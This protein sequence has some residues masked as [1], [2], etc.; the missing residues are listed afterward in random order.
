MTTETLE[1][2]NGPELVELRN[3][4]IERLAW[5]EN[6]PVASKAGPVKR[7]VSHPARRLDGPTVLHNPSNWEQTWDGFGEAPAWAEKLI[8]R[9]GSYERA[10]GYI[11]ALSVM[12]PKTN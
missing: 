12:R 1:N 3:A 6:N 10:L 9:E 5:L 11:R 2:L 8:A 7:A 4:V